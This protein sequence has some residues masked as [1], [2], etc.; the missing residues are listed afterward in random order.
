[1]TLCI[2]REGSFQNHVLNSH[3]CK[4]HLSGKVERFSGNFVLKT[5]TFL[6]QQGNPMT[7]TFTQSGTKRKISFDGTVRIKP[8]G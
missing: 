4:S 1:M 2:H 8:K 3:V 5:R 7:S 6:L